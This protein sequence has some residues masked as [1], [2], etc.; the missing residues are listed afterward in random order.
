MALKNTIVPIKLA[1]SLFHPLHVATIDNATGMVRASKELLSGTKSPGQWMKEMAQATV[2]KGAIKGTRTGYRLL[3]AYQGKLPDSDITPADTQ[4]L[5]FMAEGGM[6]PEMAAQ[7]KTNA[8]S[9]FKSAVERR[10]A[11]ALWHA[12]LAAIAMLQK[13]MFEIWIPSLKISSYLKDAQAAVMVDPSL[14]KNPIKRQAAFRRLAKSVDNRYGEMAY[15]TLFWN[16]WVKDLA[17]ANTLSL[18]WQMGFIREYGGGLMDLGHVVTK[19]GTVVEKAKSGML[20]RPLFVTFYTTQALAYG[21]LLTWALSGDEPQDLNDY[22]YPRSGNTKPDGSPERLNTMFYP[23]EFAA[24]YKHAENEGLVTGL[25]HLAANKASGVVGLTREWATGINSFGREIRDPDA[26]AFK[27]LEQTIVHTL[28]E[29]EPISVG[30]IRE[31]MSETP[32][33]SAL[34]NIAGFS[35]APQYATESKTEGLIRGTFKKYFQQKQTPFERAQYSDDRRKLR[36][37]YDSGD[38]EAYG[39][40]IDKM[41]EEYELTGLEQRKLEVSLARGEDP[42]FSMFERLTWRQQKKILDQMTQEER[43]LFLPFSNRQHLRTSYEPPE[44]SK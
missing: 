11:T 28:T 5:T 33:K 13:P 42:I 15:N 37:A 8:I 30:A 34:L 19:Q 24:I 44:E 6:I 32:V 14:M 9:S 25:G 16:R 1:L 41:Q 26:P 17:V 39:E 18:G 10:S 20:D 35:P 31:Q 3:K 36:K 27:K 40:L 23:R 29:L 21:G 7:Y 43:D 38:Q 4:A 12:P 2:Y 22:V